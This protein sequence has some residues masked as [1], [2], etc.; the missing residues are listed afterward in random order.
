MEGLHDAQENSVKTRRSS[1]NLESEHSF[2]TQ[3]LQSEVQAA[4]KAAEDNRQLASNAQAHP[5]PCVPGGH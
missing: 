4:R 2:P 1:I 3:Q 5:I